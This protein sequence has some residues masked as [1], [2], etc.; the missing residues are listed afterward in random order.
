MSIAPAPRTPTL[1]RKRERRFL[2]LAPCV[3]HSNFIRP[4]A[5]LFKYRRVA[6]PIAILRVFFKS[7]QADSLGVE[8]RFELKPVVSRRRDRPP[9]AILTAQAIHAH[10]SLSTGGRAMLTRRGFAAC[11][12]CAETMP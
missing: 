8:A 3:Q 6:A 11:A 1:S 2:S 7:S 9:R 4:F 5:L 10:N 12:R